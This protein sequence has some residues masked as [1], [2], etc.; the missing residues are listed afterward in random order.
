MIYNAQTVGK[1]ESLHCSVPSTLVL[2]AELTKKKKEKKKKLFT[3]MQFDVSSGSMTAK[4][5]HRAGDSCCLMIIP[6]GY[7]G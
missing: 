1:G 5:P 3:L 4:K 2:R 6:T 7:G